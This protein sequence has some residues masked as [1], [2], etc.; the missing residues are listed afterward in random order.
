MRRV[1]HKAW[2]LLG[3]AESEGDHRGAI[4]ALREVRE[5]LESL[6]VMLAKTNGAKSAMDGPPTKVIVEFI[7]PGDKPLRERP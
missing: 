3:R 2:E 1:H 5:C 6:G 7:G 4:V